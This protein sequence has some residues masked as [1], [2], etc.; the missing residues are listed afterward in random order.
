MGREYGGYMWF[1][2]EFSPLILPYLWPTNLDLGH[3]GPFSQRLMPK[4][5]IYLNF[6]KYNLLFKIIFNIMKSINSCQWSLSSRRLFLNHYSRFLYS[7]VKTAVMLTETPVFFIL[8][9]AW[10]IR[11]RRCPYCIILWY[12]KIAYTST[13][14][15][16]LVQFLSQVGK[17]REIMFSAEMS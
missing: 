14:G 8:P 2:K 10:K 15:R 4:C 7:I 1:R 3:C 13:K 17:G 9:G 6:K 5:A 11:D 12:I 16:I